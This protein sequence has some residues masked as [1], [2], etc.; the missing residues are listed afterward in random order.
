MIDLYP[1]VGPVLRS[2]DAEL[3]HTLSIK[4][5]GLGFGPV[6]SEPDD[7]ILRTSV[8]GLDFANPVGLAA[9][10]D[11]NAEVTGPM[12]RMGFGFV[13]AGSVT[14]R[15]QPG[16][17]KPRLFRL[18]AQGA[19]L[20][21]MGFNN[22][23]LEVFARRLED[24]R[25][26]PS[27]PPG[28]VGANLG[29][30]KD[31][32]EAADDYVLG[33]RRL[34]P[35]ADYL[36]VNVSSPNTPGLRALQGRGPLE[37][38]LRRVLEARDACATARPPVLLKIAPDLTDEDKTDIAAVALA[39]G[40]D[41]LVVSNTTIARPNGIPDRF[42]DEAGGLSG[43]PLFAASTALLG[44]IYRLTEGRLPIVG[45]G[46][47]ASADDAYAKIRAGAS[48][49]QLYSALVYGGPGLLW[50]IKSGLAGRLRRDGFSCVA[51]AVGADHR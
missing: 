27:S 30:N 51:D 25:G 39:T 4:S 10:Y 5:L 41:G 15:P 9:G 6:Q 49:V 33:V 8:W 11:K 38:L 50:A 31:T 7:P 37:T 16:N 43:R 32:V 48:L 14:P 19:V 46:G 21:R 26:T 47:I 24:R 20:N 34:A 29:K 12:L 13:E 18:P 3:A 35:L 28:V 40:I 45:V 2:L 36:V 44:E 23:G 17:P 1:L 22:E 42:R